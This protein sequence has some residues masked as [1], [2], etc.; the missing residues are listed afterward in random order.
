MRVRVLGVELARLHI[1][2]CRVYGLA[3]TRGAAARARA[4]DVNRYSYA[5]LGFKMRRFGHSDDYPERITIRVDY[6][7][8]PSVA[9]SKVYHV[10]SKRRI[11]LYPFGGQTVAS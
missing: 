11:V 6:R 3:A 5:R 1:T 2:A 9:K 7:C 10:I 8:S 4:L